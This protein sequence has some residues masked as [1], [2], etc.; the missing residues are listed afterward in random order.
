VSIL[1]V[2]A[3]PL[4]K[5]SDDHLLDISG[6]RLWRAWHELPRNSHEKIEARTGQL[7]FSYFILEV[8]VLDASFKE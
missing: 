2:N 3:D 7:S 5:E 1:Q 6:F 4:L 8:H